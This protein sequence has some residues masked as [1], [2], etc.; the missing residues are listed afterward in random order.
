[1]AK[2]SRPNIHDTLDR[3]PGLLDAYRTIAQ[4]LSEGTLT[5]VERN[6]VLIAA[7]VENGCTYC[8]PVYTLEIGHLR[9]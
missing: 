9:A 5:A 2:Q 1:M 3:A 4:T 7:S 8:V 6:V